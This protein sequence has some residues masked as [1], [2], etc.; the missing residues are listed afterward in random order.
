METDTNTTKMSYLKNLEKERQY[1]QAKVV[2]TIGP[3]C[4]NEETLTAMM[5]AGVDVFRLNFSHGDYDLH[6]GSIRM[7]REI[8]GKLNLNISILADLQGPKIRIGQV[9]EGTVLEAGAPFFLST[10]PMTGTAQGASIGY[11]DLPKVVNE[12]EEILIDDGKIR[13]KVTGTNN[14]DRVET[15]VV[16][17]GPLYSRKGVNLPQTY[18]SLPSLT[19]KDHRDAIFAME[20][21]VDWI[22]LSFVRK[23]QDMKELRALVKQQGKE[24]QVSILA[25]IEKPEVLGNIDQVLDCSD[26][27]MVARGDLGVE[28]SFEQ[29][30]IIQKEV[31]RRAVAKGKPVVVAT[32]MLESM[33]HNFAPTRAEA[34]DVANAVLDGADAVMLSGETAVGEYPVES[35]KA[36]ESII[37]FTE[38]KGFCYRPC[39]TP[40]PED[41]DFTKE[42]VSYSA[43]QMADSAQAE[44]IVLFAENKNEVMSV[45]SYRP[46]CKIF[47]FTINPL[48]KSQLGFT[49]SACVFPIEP[50]ERT[51]QA[52]AYANE[53]LLREGRL[54]HGS[55]VVYLSHI[56]FHQRGESLNTIRLEIC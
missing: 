11:Y 28:V 5:K 29:V 16:N 49:W 50:M 13:L 12:G 34:N 35:V 7:I 30:P 36:M 38:R 52:A 10:E 17:G 32:Q 24:G 54:H 47:V 26:G 22:G 43:V 42:V 33:I 31:I 37:R 6:A 51:A 23:P 9:E 53:V 55:R 39:K 40:N 56:P 21:G 2:A 18:V 25:K 8:A 41:P 14:A 3:A 27:I 1:S 15:E 48:L 46:N 45:A 19:E 4:R 44:A 20:Q